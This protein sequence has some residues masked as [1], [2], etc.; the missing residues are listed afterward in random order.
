M[1]L[2]EHFGHLFLCQLLRCK[3]RSF[4]QKSNACCFLTIFLPS[5]PPVKSCFSPLYPLS[6]SHF[7]HYYTWRF[8]KRLEST[9]LAN[10]PPVP[11]HF[12]ISFYCF[13]A[14]V[15]IFISRKDL[16]LCSLHGPLNETD[17]EISQLCFKLAPL[18]DVFAFTWQQHRWFSV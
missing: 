7:Q 3:C 9:R 15:W 13:Y 4:I 12:F 5:I 11:P 14:S 1:V 10:M 17:S 8:I 18:A 16:V 6:H 2:S